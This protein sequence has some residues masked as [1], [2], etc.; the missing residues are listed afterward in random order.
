LKINNTTIELNNDD[1]EGGFSAERIEI[2]AADA[3]SGSTDH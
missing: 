3:S 2:G 1:F